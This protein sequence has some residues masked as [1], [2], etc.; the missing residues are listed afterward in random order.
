MGIRIVE[1]NKE[2]P[3]R[4]WLPGLLIWIMLLPILIL[5]IVPICLVVIGLF[6]WNLV[7]GQG[8]TARAYTKIFFSIP[9]LFWALR[10][11]TVD[12]DSKDTIVKI[13]F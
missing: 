3:F 1:K 13:K 2:K 11:L 12:I 6:I 4:L 5:L 7:P 8:K 10:G 9:S